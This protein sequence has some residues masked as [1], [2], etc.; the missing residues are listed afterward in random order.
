[1]GKE[2]EFG[3]IRHRRGGDGILDD[4]EVLK[5]PGWMANEGEQWQAGV[6]GRAR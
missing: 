2:P 4:A 1:M 5:A 6:G 3:V